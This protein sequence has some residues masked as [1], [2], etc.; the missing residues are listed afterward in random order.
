M[1]NEKGPAQKARRPGTGRQADRAA[2][3]AGHSRRAR[4]IGEV[5]SGTFGPTLRKSIAMAYVDANF[6][7]EGTQLAADLKRTLNPAK[8]VKLPFYKDRMP[9]MNADP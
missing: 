9:Q 2:G 6:A 8:V 7:A 3:D 5:T 4:S 1:I